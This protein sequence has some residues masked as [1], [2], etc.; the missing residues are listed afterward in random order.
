MSELGDFLQ[1]HYYKHVA[2]N[3]RLRNFDDKQQ[4]KPIR[5][6]MAFIN[7]KESIDLFCLYLDVGYTQ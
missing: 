4:I 3:V 2:N 5:Y 6:Q 7:L 1:C